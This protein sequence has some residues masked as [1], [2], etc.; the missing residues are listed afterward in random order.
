[1]RLQPGLL[2]LVVYGPG[3]G[4]SV[5]VRVPP[6][7]WLVVDGCTIGGRSP[8]ARLLADQQAEWSCVVLTHPH[9]DHV[10]GLDGVREVSG[11]GPIGCAVPGALDPRLWADSIDAS[12]QLGNGVLEHVMAA[13]HDRWTA[14]PACRWDMRRGD[15]RTVGE[16]EVEVLHPDD[17]LAWCLQ[18]VDRVHLT[19][20]PV[21]HDLQSSVPC[22]TT[23]QAL[24]RERHQRAGLVPCPPGVRFYRRPST[25]EW[26]DPCFV[27][28]GFREDG[29]LADLKHGPGSALVREGEEKT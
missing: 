12:E 9:L 24:A 19:G 23:R 6:D 16:M 22:E 2:Y 15:R 8:A 11:S 28:A 13:I 1:M 29:S 27:A 25:A 17:G 18:Q 21:A 14:D 26:G 4:E 20:L 7:T 5:L 10:L 3:F